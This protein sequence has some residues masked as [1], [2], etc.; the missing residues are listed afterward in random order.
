[1]PHA[2]VGMLV[3]AALTGIPNA[4]AGVRLALHGRG[5]AV[6]T[7]SFNSNTVNI[8]AGL[9]L[10][11]LFVGLGRISPRTVFALWWLGGMTI[12]AIVFTAWGGGLRRLGGAVLLV[13]YA[14]FFWMIL[15]W[16]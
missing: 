6:V 3:I 7:E 14:A 8:V 9:C 2:A 16:R 5:A 4:I 13:L 11:A 10:P 12:V 15:A 1:L